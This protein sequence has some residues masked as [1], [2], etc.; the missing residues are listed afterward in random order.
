VAAVQVRVGAERQMDTDTQTNS[1][2]HRHR[3]SRIVDAHCNTH[4]Q[5]EGRGNRRSMEEH[6]W[7]EE[8]ERAN[9]SVL[10]S[11]EGGGG[12]RRRQ[13]I[14]GRARRADFGGNSD[15]DTTTGATN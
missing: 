12:R 1:H 13:E 6:E 15:T 2:S 14:N 9:E 4:K 5:A 11:Q 10:K 7:K 8:K 3:G